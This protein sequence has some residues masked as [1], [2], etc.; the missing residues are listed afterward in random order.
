MDKKPGTFKE[1]RPGIYR[2]ATPLEKQSFM[3]LDK[4]A[5]DLYGMNEMI[6]HPRVPQKALQDFLRLEQ[7]QVELL[8]K[9][10]LLNSNI[11]QDYELIKT[12]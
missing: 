7:V 2:T 9:L 12:C 8:F 10:W 1:L 5:K 4:L 11:K 3:Y 6:M